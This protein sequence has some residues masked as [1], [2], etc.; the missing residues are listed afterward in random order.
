MFAFEPSNYSV[1]GEIALNK[2]DEDLISKL[3]NVAELFNKTTEVLTRKSD[4]EL[5]LLL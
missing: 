5:P 4:D 1:E 2:T 3:I